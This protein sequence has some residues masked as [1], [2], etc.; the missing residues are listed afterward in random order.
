MSFFITLLQVR[1]PLFTGSYPKR[2][3]L[4]G[5]QNTVIAVPVATENVPAEQTQK[6]ATIC[7]KITVG[8]NKKF[9]PSLQPFALHCAGRVRAKTRCGKKSRVLPQRLRF[10]QLAIL[11]L[12]GVCPASEVKH[13]ERSS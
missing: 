7:T 5:M 8:R 1:N 10:I 6:A 13:R 12:H 9:C 11:S 4:L 2:K 3:S